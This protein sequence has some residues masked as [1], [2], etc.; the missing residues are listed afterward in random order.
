MLPL[1]AGLSEPPDTASEGEG[2]DLTC[3]RTNKFPTTVLKIKVSVCYMHIFNC[4]YDYFKWQHRD[5]FYYYITLY[6][7]LVEELHTMVE[8]MKAD[9]TQPSSGFGK[10]LAVF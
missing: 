8:R 9:P 1:D 7:P 2:S 3:A 10:I 6:R 5:L 4:S